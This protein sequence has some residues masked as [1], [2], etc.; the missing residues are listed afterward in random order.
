MLTTTSTSYPRDLGNGLILRWS[1]S[2]DSEKIA[3][4]TSNVFRSSSEEPPSTQM[5][6]WVRRLMR[7]DHPLMGP[8]AF[9]VV[10][11]CSKEGHP[12]VASTC[13]WRQDWEYEGIR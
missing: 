11:D 1:T 8:G 10:E 7:G 13:L 3:Q 5:G 9:G 4:L 12:L 6:N 2:K